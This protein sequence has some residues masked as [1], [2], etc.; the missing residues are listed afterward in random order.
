MEEKIKALEMNNL[1]KQRFI[2]NLTHELK[3]PL[4]SIIG[5]AEFLR[6]TKYD[7]RVFVDGLDWRDGSGAC[8]EGGGKAN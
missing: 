2:H 7:E 6:V 3:T 4:T 1:E 8:L 5:Y